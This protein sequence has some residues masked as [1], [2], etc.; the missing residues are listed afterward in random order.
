MVLLVPP[1]AVASC[2]A[3]WMIVKNEEESLAS[4]LVIVSRAQ[5]K[6]KGTNLFSAGGG[7][8]M[9]RERVEHKKYLLIVARFF[10]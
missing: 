9:L 3:D 1:A 10:V 2:P 5:R 8:P 6:E 7:L 4:S